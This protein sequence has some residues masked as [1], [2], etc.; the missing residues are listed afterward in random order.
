MIKKETE[1]KLLLHL[2]ISIMLLGLF[3]GGILGSIVIF[4]I[5]I[6]IIASTIFSMVFAGIKEEGEINGF[7]ILEKRI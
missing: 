4:G 2:S 7:W 6:I 3:I 1:S 5:G